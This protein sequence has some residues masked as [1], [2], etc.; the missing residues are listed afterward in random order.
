MIL[1][2]QLP[3]LRENKYLLFKTASLWYFVITAL[4]DEYRAKRDK[5]G[6]RERKGKIKERE[7]TIKLRMDK[8]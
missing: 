5:S 7:V 3:E 1:G 2:L 8:P 6:R 4:A